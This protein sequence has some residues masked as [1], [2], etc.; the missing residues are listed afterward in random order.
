MSGSKR[1][2]GGGTPSISTSLPRA[3][4]PLS[5]RIAATCDETLPE[6]WPAVGATLRMATLRMAIDLQLDRQACDELVK[7]R[8]RYSILKKGAFVAADEGQELM[9]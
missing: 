7:M 9:R 3:A 5:R 8:H 6:D 4:A 1:P 2:H